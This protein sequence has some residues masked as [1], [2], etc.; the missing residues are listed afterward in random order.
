MATNPLLTM[1]LGEPAYQ[2]PPYQTIQ[3][4]RAYVGGRWRTPLVAL[5]WA[6][7]L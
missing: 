3:R 1:A 6:D 7:R 5:I 4:Y 2:K